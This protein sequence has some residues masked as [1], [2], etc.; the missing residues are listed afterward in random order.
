MGLLKQIFVCISCLL[1]I[2]F[3]YYIR[4]VKFGIHHGIVTNM[5]FAAK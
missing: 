4:R 2:Y 3:I 5:R 1:N